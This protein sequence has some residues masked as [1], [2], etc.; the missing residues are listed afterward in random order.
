MFHLKRTV[1]GHSKA[2]SSVKFDPNGKLIASS[3]KKDKCFFLLLQ[4]VFC[5]NNTLLLAA[6]KSIK[7][8]NGSLEKDDPDVTFCGHELGVSDV[9]WSPNSK[10]LASASDD[11]CV[12]LWDVESGRSLVSMGGNDQGHTNYVL[13]VA[14]NPQGTL[15]AS[16]SYD[17]TVRFW[18][19]RTAKC[20]RVLPAHSEPITSVSFSYDGTMLVTGSYDCLSR[21]WDVTSGQ[22][23]KTLVNGPTAPVSSAIFSPNAHFVLITTLDG[24]LR[25]WDYADGKCAKTFSGHFNEKMPVFSTF[26]YKTPAQL[27]ASGSED[28]A[29]YIWDVQAQETYQVLNGHDDPVVGLSANPYRPALVSAANTTVKLWEMGSS[30][31]L[32][33]D[34]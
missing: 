30:P 4:F 22:C 29:V 12:R 17:E 7:V 21:I 15:I 27:V 16:G 11:R 10:Y 19:A 31:S 1:R 32:N 23:L 24:H 9:S 34:M 20:V 2:I 6:D 8:W 28:G 3:C 25:L 13:C 33:R 26:V 5:N 14:F 18:D